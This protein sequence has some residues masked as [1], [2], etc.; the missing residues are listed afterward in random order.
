MYHYINF[1]DAKTMREI[2]SKHFSAQDEELVEKAI[3]LFYQFRNMGLERAPSTRELLNWLK[4]LHSVHKNDAIEQLMSMDGIGV[5]LKTKE[6]IEKA[7]RR[8]AYLAKN[9]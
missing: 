3:D 2:I 9:N 7:R 5:L 8:L 1:P 6:D 4:Y